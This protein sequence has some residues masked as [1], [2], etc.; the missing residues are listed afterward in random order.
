MAKTY[1]TNCG[2]LEAP[3]K[4]IW[5]FKDHQNN[6]LQLYNNEEKQQETMQT[7]M[8]SITHTL[9]GYRIKVLKGEEEEE[10]IMKEQS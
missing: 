4:I 8:V 5:T 1:S 9:K 7:K 2:N 3:H 6:N 10:I